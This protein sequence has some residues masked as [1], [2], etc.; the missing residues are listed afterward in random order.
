MIFNSS[1]NSVSNSVSKL[2]LLLTLVIGKSL[3]EAI[4]EEGLE[5]EGEENRKEGRRCHENEGDHDGGTTSPSEDV[6]D[7]E[8]EDNE[9]GREEGKGS[10]ER[11]KDGEEGE[12]RLYTSESLDTSSS[13]AMISMGLEGLCGLNKVNSNNVNVDDSS[14]NPINTGSTSDENG[15]IN[16][17]NNDDKNDNN[18]DDNSEAKRGQSPK[19]VEARFFKDAQTSRNSSNDRGNSSS[20][21]D[22]GVES[23]KGVEINR[24]SEGEERDKYEGTIEEKKTSRKDMIRIDNKEKDED[25]NMHLYDRAELL[26][27]M[28]TPSHAV[29]PI[30]VQT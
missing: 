19:R 18:K 21:G 11:G 17:D 1:S 8:G 7:V 30:R 6:G 23:K 20:G 13:A 16:L 24:E 9:E 15:V 3:Y 28:R 5:S 12:D 26:L 25:G 22:S 14:G 29:S 2:N 10:Q 4:G 27:T